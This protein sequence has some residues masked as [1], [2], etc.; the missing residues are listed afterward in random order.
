MN[1]NIYE[2]LVL[3]KHEYMGPNWTQAEGYI[4][5]T[6]ANIFK[7]AGPV[8]AYGTAAAVIY[9]IIYWITTLS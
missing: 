8:I 1:V 7:I 9:G 3:M 5:G 4:L 2:N 6:G